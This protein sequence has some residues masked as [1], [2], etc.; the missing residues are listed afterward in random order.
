MSTSTEQS[1]PTMTISRQSRAGVPSINGTE[2]MKTF[3]GGTVW[4]DLVV[5]APGGELSVANVLRVTAGSGWICDRGGQPVRIDVGD[6]IWCP[7]GTVHWHGADD[8][9][10]MVHQATS[11]GKAEW[12]EPVTD[13]VYKAK[14]RS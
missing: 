1:K 5:S 7:P 2:S 9:S 10:Y 4:V 6:V 13:D 11:L 12:L 14:K 8:D 3:T